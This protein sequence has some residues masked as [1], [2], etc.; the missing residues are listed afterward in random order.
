MS[1][2][3]LFRLLLLVA[4]MLLFGVGIRQGSDMLRWIGIGCIG[5]ALVVRMAGRIAGRR[6][7][8]AD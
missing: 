6:K 1:G 3:V 2:L 8:T 5:G 7:D 4:G